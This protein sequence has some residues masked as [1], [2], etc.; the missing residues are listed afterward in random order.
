MSFRVETSRLV[1]R[2]WQAE[3]RARFPR[4]VTDPDMLR[5][6]RPGRAWDSAR[7]EA[8]FLRQSRH[9]AEHGCCVGA[10]VLKENAELIG[11]GGIQPLGASGEFE[12]VWWIWKEYWG[13]GLATELARGL[14]DYAFSVLRL[15]RVAAVVDPPNLASMR[16]A[17]KLGMRCAG[18]RRAREFVREH[19][20]DEPLYYYVL[21]RPAPQSGPG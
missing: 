12:L 3:D 1:V 4:L 11:M 14:K 9:L 5:H 20:T 6:V 15:P 16:V 17:E 10:V 19:P 8:Y 18:L 13:R 7:I 2:P 21:E